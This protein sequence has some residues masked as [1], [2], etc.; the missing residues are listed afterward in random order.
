MRSRGLQ[1]AGIVTALLMGTA[2]FSSAQAAQ[3]DGA[4][5]MSSFGAN[6]VKPTGGSATLETATGLDFTTQQFEVDGP[7]TGDFGAF[8]ADGQ[9]GSILDFTFSPSGPVDSLWSVGGFSFDADAIAI[10]VQV[11]GFLS[12]QA[13]GTVSGNGFDETPG[14]WRFTTQGD[15]GDV[16]EFS[17]SATQSAFPRDIPEP[18]TLALLGAGL[19]G[20]VLGRRRRA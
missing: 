19:M 20:L 9:V 8:L 4:F 5:N 7:V 16:T 3:I 18:A 13:T 17:F 10:I 2:A 12:L 15:N 1:T 14:M 6:L 11:D